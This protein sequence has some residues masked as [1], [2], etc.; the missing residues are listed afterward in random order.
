MQDG[1]VTETDLRTTQAQRTHATIR[2]AALILIR[3]YGY[4]TVTVDDVAAPAGVPRHT[5]FSHFASKA[6]PPVVGLEPPVLAAVEAF[7]SGSGNLLEDLSALLASNAESVGLERGWLLSLLEVVRD[8]P[9][10]E[11]AAH[12][13]PRIIV[14]SLAEAVGRR[15]GAGSGGLCIR[16]VIALVIAVQYSP[17]DLWY[18]RSHP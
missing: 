18:G 3:E 4:A 5:V 6:D 2:I 13:R 12:E 9:E 10:M 15:P 7:V 14:Q 8:D 11:R 17:L 16:V 1:G